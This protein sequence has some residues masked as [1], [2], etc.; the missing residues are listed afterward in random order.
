M[1]PAALLAAKIDDISRFESPGQ[2]ISWTGMC[3]VLHPSR[4]VECHGRMSGTTGR[5]VNWIMI[6]CALTACTHDPRMR[7][8]Y[9]RLKTRHKPIVALAHLAN[10]LPRTIGYWIVHVLQCKFADSLTGFCN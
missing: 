7:K 2:I 3:P 5:R 4:G 10:K 1:P 9:E 6:Q 8:Y